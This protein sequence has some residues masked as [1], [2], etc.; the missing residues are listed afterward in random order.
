MIKI[1]I[2]DDEPLAR[3][4]LADLLAPEADLQVIGQAGNAVEAIAAINRLHPDVVFLD[5]QMPQISG[6]QLLTMLDPERMPHIVFVTAFDEFAVQAF[7][8][9]AFDYLLK[10]VEPAR[11]AKTLARLRKERGPQP[12][13]AIGGNVPLTQLP[14]YGHNRVYLLKVESVEYALSRLSGVYLVDADGNEHF[15]ELTL[16]TLEDKTPL[17]RCHRQHLVNPARIA[18]IRFGDNGAA[19][20]HT[21]GGLTVPVSRRFLRAVKDALG[22]I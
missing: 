2:V 5:I 22:I 11:L 8:E 14:C 4:E 12:L 13:G 17:L 3:D 20:I 10:P 9:H 19:D 16:K 7:E 1:L 18:E 15:T 21:H 6:L